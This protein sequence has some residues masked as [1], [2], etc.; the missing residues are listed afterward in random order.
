MGEIIIVQKVTK[1]WLAFALK[2]RL[3]CSIT[4]DQFDQSN[5]ASV[6]LPVAMAAHR[7]CHIIAGPL[8]D[9]LTLQIAEEV[10]RSFGGWVAPCPVNAG[11]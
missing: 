1:K 4:A 6:D 5:L 3:V 8:N 11:V 7:C 10:E 2:C 9:N